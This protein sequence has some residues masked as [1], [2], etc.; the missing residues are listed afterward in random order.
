MIEIWGMALSGS[1]F[2]GRARSR[3]IML[4]NAV[5]AWCVSVCVLVCGG[6]GSWKLLLWIW[7]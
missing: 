7:D 6:S 2:V 4:A 1:V 3:V 5:V